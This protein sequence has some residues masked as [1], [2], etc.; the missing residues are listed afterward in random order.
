[1]CPLLQV[2]YPLHCWIYPLQRSDW[3]P[4]YSIPLLISRT[5]ECCNLHCCSGHCS[6]WD[7]LRSPDSRKLKTVQPISSR[8]C[9]T[10]LSPGSR[11]AFDFW[12]VIDAMLIN[13]SS[14]TLVWKNEVG[15]NS[16]LRLYTVKSASSIGVIRGTGSTRRA[17]P[18]P[19]RPTGEKSTDGTFVSTG[20][21]DNNAVEYTRGHEGDSVAERSVRTLYG[22]QT[23]TTQRGK[24]W[25]K[26]LSKSLSEQ[27]LSPNNQS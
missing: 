11:R 27:A 2:N 19:G 23:H 16:S 10:F 17:S 1:M 9:P 20:L 22:K 4:C 13:W 15:G 21:G 24:G 5:C 12:S 18:Y 25:S 26:Q 3:R 7:Y 6:G 8:R 14:L